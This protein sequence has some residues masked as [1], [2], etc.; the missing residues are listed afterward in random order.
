MERG[1]SCVR[2][3]SWP[4][5]SNS[6]RRFA[7]EASL[8][9]KQARFF[10]TRRRLGSGSGAGSFLPAA[11]FPLFRRSVEGSTQPG[12][13]RSSLYESVNSVKKLHNVYC[14][15]TARTEQARTTNG[16]K[17]SV[18]VLRVN[19]HHLYV[20]RPPRASAKGLLVGDKPDLNPTS[21]CT[22]GPRRAGCGLLSKWA[23]CSLRLAPC[24]RST[25]EPQLAARCYSLGPVRCSRRT[26]HQSGD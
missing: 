12:E 16:G 23:R 8:I 10:Q 1:S 3:K 15:G 4:R 19:R 18:K 17:Q 20:A 21:Q 24:A 5:F 11:F 7:L 6:N 9:D 2:M 25:H 14:F 22:D 13:K 26:G